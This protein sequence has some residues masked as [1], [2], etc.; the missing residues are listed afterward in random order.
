MA[1]RKSLSADPETIELLVV[2]PGQDCLH[3]VVLDDLDLVE[4]AAAGRGEPDEDDPAV[5]RDAD[6]LDETALL[7]PVDE[8]GGVRQRDVEELGEAA[9]RELA[10]LFEAPHDVEMRH[11][12][13]LLHEPT[14]RRAADQAHRAIQLVDDAG[15]RRPAG[16]RR[17]G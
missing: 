4:E 10:G 17:G 8:P 1:L 12:D 9:H 6:P 5:V 15:D 2:E 11:A 7:H 14:G 3:Q 13:P 16:S